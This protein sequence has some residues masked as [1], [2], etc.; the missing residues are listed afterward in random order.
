MSEN[1][2]EILDSFLPENEFRRIS[3]VLMGPEFPWY[4]QF[5]VPYKED[6]ELQQKIEPDPSDFYLT[7][8]MFQGGVIKSNF[9]DLCLPITKKLE[10]YLISRINVNLYPHT[11]RNYAHG[12]HID[13]DDDLLSAVFYVNTNNGFTLFGDGEKV[14]SVE[15]RICIFPSGLPHSSVTCTDSSARVVVSLAFAKPNKR[16]RHPQNTKG[17]YI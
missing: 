1:K 8:I 9:I 14:N 15:N 7:H 5:G 17:F 12:F 13:T 10:I 11:D 6:E 16:N 3:E 2:V 4:L